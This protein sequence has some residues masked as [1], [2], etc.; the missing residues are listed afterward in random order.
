MKKVKKR[1]RIGIVSILTLTFIVLKATG[2]ISWPWLW[3]L[4]PIWISLLLAG[5]IFAAIL[6]AGRIKKGKW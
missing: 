5:L 2:M 1:D 6:I 4:S 3:V